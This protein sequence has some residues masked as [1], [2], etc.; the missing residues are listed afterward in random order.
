[1][2]DERSKAEQARGTATLLRNTPEVREKGHV[3]SDGRGSGQTGP[4]RIAMAL[5]DSLRTLGFIQRTGCSVR[6]FRGHDMPHLHLGKI[7]MTIS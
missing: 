4:D 2:G 3:R 5:E 7:V 6:G 1:M